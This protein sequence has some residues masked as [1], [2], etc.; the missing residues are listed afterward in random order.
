MG[1]V[2]QIHLDLVFLRDKNSFLALFTIQIINGKDIFIGTFRNKTGLRAPNERL[3]F[4]G[5]TWFLYPI[6]TAL[7]TVAFKLSSFNP[8]EFLKSNVVEDFA[9]SKY[10]CCWAEALLVFKS[11]G[12]KVIFLIVV[13][14]IHG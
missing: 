13:I 12:T 5:N 3:K 1:K 4:S 11:K 6:A 9:P 8:C 7:E 14:V 2:I 10:S